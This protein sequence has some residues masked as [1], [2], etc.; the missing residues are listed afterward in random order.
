MFLKQTSSSEYEFRLPREQRWNMAV[1]GAL[2][3]YGA[4]RRFGSVPVPAAGQDEK[5]TQGNKEMLEKRLKT[6]QKILDPKTYPLV[7]E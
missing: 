3:Y 6:A 7:G 5:T 1:D 4:A 2:T